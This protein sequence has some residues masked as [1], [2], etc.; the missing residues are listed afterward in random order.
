[1]R[2]YYYFVATLPFISYDDPPS[3][4][5]EEFRELCYSLLEPEDAE[6]VQYCRYD[7]QMAVETVQPTG[8]DFIDLLMARERT[9]ALNLAYLRAARLKRQSPGDPPHDVPRAEA[10]AKAAFEMEDPLQASLYI[11]RARWGALDA[12]VGIDLFG[13]NNIFAYLMK[14]QLLERK[15]SFD[16]EKGSVEYRKLYDTILNEYNTKA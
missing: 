11:D 2:N 15:Q 14:L 5:S 16:T 4:S 7:S 6:M 10:V 3:M 12:M 13:V 8:S 9:L 1:M